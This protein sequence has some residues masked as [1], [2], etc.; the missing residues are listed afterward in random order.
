M[1]FK[2]GIGQDA[3]CFLSCEAEK[4]CILGGVVFDE[5]PGLKA[6]SDGDVVLHAICNAI[7]S[8]TGVLILGDVADRLCFEEKICDSKV[9]LEE[10][11][12][13]LDGYKITHVALSIECE[14]PKINP[15]IMLMRENVSK[16]INV[17]V[18]QVCITATTGNGINVGNNNGVQCLCIVTIMGIK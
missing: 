1:L 7:S 6:N 11:L 14:K 10:A 3:H 16:I 17:D 15:K 9:Y 2:T 4:P 5:V 18:S 13:T 8:I 12:K